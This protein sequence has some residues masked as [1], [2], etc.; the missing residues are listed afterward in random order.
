[1]LAAMRPNTT[2]EQ[3]SQMF[4]AISPSYDRVNRILSFG[5]DA[6]WRK[7]LIPHLP[8][9]KE[10]HLLDLA[11]GTCDQ[12][13]TL[14]SS[15]KIA[16]A[17]GIDLAD[18]ML[19]IGKK[20]VAQS[21]FEERVKLLNASALEIPSLDESF[22]CVSISF[23]IRNVQGNGLKEIYRVLK[24]GG[25]A[26]IL[27][28]SL[29]KTPFFKWGHLFYLR[30]CLPKIGGLFSQKQSAYRYLNQTIESFPY[31]ETFLQKMGGEGFVNLQAHPFTFGSV[32]L[33]TGDKP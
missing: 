4:N 1:M 19:E 33:Y 7:K 9:G 20:K 25:R 10:L 22:D 6:K 24:R 16:S 23:G 30:H 15:G 27:E 29:P 18:E 2:Q 26:L 5:L 11:T 21:G 31:G 32:T 17:W 13:L 14:M 8:D 12:L 28:F 3:V